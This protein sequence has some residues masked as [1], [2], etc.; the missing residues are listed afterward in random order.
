VADEKDASKEDIRDRNRRLR[1]EAA[2]RRA[3]RRDELDEAQ[4][5]GLDAGEQAQDML[6][7]STDSAWKWIKQNF[8]VLQWVL[9]AVFAAL[10][11]WWITD[12]RSTI[13]TQETSDTL[14]V[15]LRAEQSVVGDP[16]KPDE[17]V[18]GIEDPRQIFEDVAR[19]QKQALEAYSEVESL[20]PGSPLATLSELG[21][22]GVLY[23]QGKYTDARAKYE[24]VGESPLAMGDVDVRGRALEGAGL[25][26]EGAGE[27]DAA[28]TAFRK[29]GKVDA[30]RFQQ[31]ALVHETR[32]LVAQGKDEEAKAVAK[33]L[34]AALVKDRKFGL[35]TDRGYLVAAN[36]LQLSLL[37][38]NQD[39]GELLRMIMEQAQPKQPEPAPGTP[40]TPDNGDE[41]AAV[42]TDTPK[43]V[44]PDAPKEP[45]PEAPSAKPAD[46]PAEKP[47][48]APAP[49]DAGTQD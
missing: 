42:P 8:K 13:S 30:P 9:L 34:Q 39:E 11:V 10:V 33:Q 35:L 43:E 27:L 5:L 46:A 40:A 49:G 31:M 28:L 23:D 25:S 14:A 47:A 44:A 19:A 45:A 2:A 4:N 24:A 21:V 36:K 3:K 22:A 16:S 18:P 17:P 12:A 38:P 48:D 41:K 20:E 37:D 26:S 7:R 15:A 6:A 29:M 1:A 32:I